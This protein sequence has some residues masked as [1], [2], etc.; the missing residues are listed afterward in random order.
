MPAKYTLVLRKDLRKDAVEGSK[1]YYANAKATGTCDMYELCDLISLSSTAS[2]GD[3]RLILDSLIEVMKRSL[4]KGEVVQVGELGNFQLQF[5]SSG[6][7]T[8]KEF[9]Q[10]LIKSKRIVFRPGKV[11]REA[12]ANFSFERLLI[13]RRKEKG[14]K[15][16]VET[17]RRSNS[18][19]AVFTAHPGAGRYSPFVGE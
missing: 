12:V 9:N 11:L 10:S 19:P 7:A 13:R 6:T 14:R 3:V 18:L 8:K 2:P 15:A 1:L 17:A 4:G 5:G 16:V